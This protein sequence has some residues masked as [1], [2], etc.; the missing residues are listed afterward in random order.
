MIEDV[1][2]LDTLVDNPEVTPEPEAPEIEEPKKRSYEDN[3]AELN[4]KNLR[5]IAE[6]ESL[7]AQQAEERLKELERSR[8]SHED[9]ELDSDDIMD[10]KEFKK[11]YKKINETN[12]TQAKETERLRQE[13]QYYQNIATEE[14]LKNKF[15]GFTTVV[16]EKNLAKL[17]D[18]DPVLFKSIM[19]NDT[20]ID[21]GEAA[22]KILKNH[23]AESKNYDDQ[24]ARL[25]D[26]R[27][28]P[29][30]A[31]TVAGRESQVTPLSTFQDK[32]RWKPELKY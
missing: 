22:Y 5:L 10:K 13:L 9:D 20:L 24:N 12:A 21:R 8:S 14:I 15:K 29:K 26:N 3:A 28:K 11:Y 1:T 25:E 17:K 2:S 4:L 18:E 27:Q 7:R 30:A 6:R 19:A 16:N 32:K 23:L 31:A